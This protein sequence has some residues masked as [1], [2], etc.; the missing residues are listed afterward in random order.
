MPPTTDQSEHME[1]Q[2]ERIEEGTETGTKKSKLCPRAR[3]LLLAALVLTLVGAVFVVTGTTGT[4]WIVIDQFHFGIFKSCKMYNT[5]C[6]WNY[7]S[8]SPHN[9]DCMYIYYRHM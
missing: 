9:K 3:N 7:E 2:H 5:N 8:S 1:E 4:F 6:R